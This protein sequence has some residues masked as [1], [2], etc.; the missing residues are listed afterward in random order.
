M[1]TIQIAALFVCLVCM[2]ACCMLCAA[3]RLE[4]DNTYHVLDINRLAK[5]SPGGGLVASEG[6]RLYYQNPW[7]IYDSRGG[8]IMKTDTEGNVTIGEGR[9]QD[10]GAV[11]RD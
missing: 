3:A 5:V 4:Y 1:T 2:V 7:S 8:L 9:V 10:A 11:S 6:V